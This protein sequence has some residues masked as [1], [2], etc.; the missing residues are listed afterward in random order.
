MYTLCTS[1]GVK[2]NVYYIYI[3]K[4][5]RERETYTL[6]LFTA[7]WSR[8]DEHHFLYRALMNFLVRYGIHVKN[9]VLKWFMKH[10]N[11]RPLS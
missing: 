1:I 8:Y 11:F 6:C 7:K 4:R 10:P 9:H 3:H 5:E 2:K